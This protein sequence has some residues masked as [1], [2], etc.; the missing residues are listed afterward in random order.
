M[1]GRLNWLSSA[2]LFSDEDEDLFDVV[3]PLGSKILVGCWAE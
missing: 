2:P 3:D 1:E